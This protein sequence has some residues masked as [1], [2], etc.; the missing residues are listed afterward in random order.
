MTLIGPICALLYAE[1]HIVQH[2]KRC[3]LMLKYTK[4]DRKHNTPLSF[5]RQIT[6][7]NSGMGKR[8]GCFI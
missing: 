3:N 2:K 4:E 7:N 1:V 8:L 5:P 6:K